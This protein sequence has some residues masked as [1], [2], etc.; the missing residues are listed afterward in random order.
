[1]LSSLDCR[2]YL[3][4]GYAVS[5]SRNSDVVLMLGGGGSTHVRDHVEEHQRGHRLLNYI[6]ARRWG[7]PRGGNAVVSDGLSRNAVCSAPVDT[8]SP[9]KVRPHIRVAYGPLRPFL[10]RHVDSD[11]PGHVQPRFAGQTETVLLKHMC[12]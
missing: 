6:T 7:S 3:L 10:P 1:M 8:K 11:F 12:S 9:S 2:F 4:T 5:T